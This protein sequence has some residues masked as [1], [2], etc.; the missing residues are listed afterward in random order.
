MNNIPRRATVRISS[1]QTK[2]NALR[3]IDFT[4]VDTS[5]CE[6]RSFSPKGILF[7]VTT[8]TSYSFEV[9]DDG[10]TY[11]P[12]R[13]RLNAVITVAKTAAEPSAHYLSAQIFAAFNFFKVVSNSAEAADRDITLTGYPV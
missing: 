9:S 13:D 4:T 7:P 8:G 2:S 10:N 3:T 6:N 11:Y 12:L 5:V 1:G